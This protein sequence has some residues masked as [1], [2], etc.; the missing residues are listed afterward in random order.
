MSFE[1]KNR[2][3]NKLIDVENNLKW[4]KLQIPLNITKIRKIW[5][6]ILLYPI[7]VLHYIGRGLVIVFPSSAFFPRFP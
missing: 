6:H 1:N 7:V 5:V 3:N 2:T 4:N